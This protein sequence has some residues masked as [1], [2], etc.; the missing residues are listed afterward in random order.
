MRRAARLV[1]TLVAFALSVPAFAQ[2][3]SRPD[4]WIDNS[5]Q[6]SIDSFVDDARRD[7]NGED[8][9]VGYTFALRDG[10]HVDCESS[11]GRRVSFGSDDLHFH[12]D[13]DDVDLEHS[14]GGDFGLFFRFTGTDDAIERVRM[15]SMSRAERRFD[16]TVVWAGDLDANESVQ[17]LRALVFDDGGGAARGLS[18]SRDRDRDRLFTALVLHD[19]SAADAIVFEALEP[20]Q[21]GDVRRSAVFWVSQV[22]GERGLETLLDLARNDA[23]ADVRQQSIFWLA[24][25]A[26]ER[27]TQDLADIAT[28]DPDTE[29]RKSAVF[30]LSQSDDAAAVDALIEIVRTHDNREV[31]KSAL[32][33]LGQSGDPR[34]IT[35][36][37][38]LLFG[39]R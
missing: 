8:F 4:E 33:W 9:W 5:A 2:T 31:V 14:C 28:D 24:Q 38:E 20:A 6:S 22:G 7:A 21:S 32:F 34:A 16:D 12:F 17:M 36:I 27:A 15:T 25:V 26:G 19:S 13:D 37:E 23:D 29:V 11:D 18:V 39:G 1:I 35:L 30:A 3:S 10:V